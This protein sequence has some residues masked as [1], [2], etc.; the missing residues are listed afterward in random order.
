MFQKKATTHISVE[1]DRIKTLRVGFILGLA[2]CAASSGVAAEAQIIAH[3]T[4]HFAVSAKA[5]GKADPTETIEVSIWLNRHN[6]NEMDALAQDLY[7]PNSAHYRHWLT[8]P[9][10]TARFAPTAEEV[11]TVQDFFE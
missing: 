2:L 5:V 7:A 6:G 3:N 9:Q 8:Q 11:K 10:I 4:P 1:V